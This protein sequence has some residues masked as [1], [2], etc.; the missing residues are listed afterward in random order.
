MEE[1]EEEEEE[2]KGPIRLDLNELIFAWQDESPDNA[3]YLDTE[4]GDVKL[5]NRN[6]LDLRDLTDDIERER[7]RYK[8][9]PKP[10]RQQL[11]ADLKQFHETVKDERLKS[12]LSMAFESPHVLSAF[13]KI[14]EKEP[15]E[16]K[17][18]DEFRTSLAKKRIEA[19]LT[20]NFID[21]E[22]TGSESKD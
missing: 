4:S 18:L 22:F 15:D 20:A 7:W 11:P 13:K 16:Q 12:I 2:R 1:E 14:L 9:M 6:L 5:V 19:W 3:Y 21:Y 10:D 8:Y 17:R